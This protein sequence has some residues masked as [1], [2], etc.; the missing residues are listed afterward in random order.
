MSNGLFQTTITAFS[1]DASCQAL[2]AEFILKA[3]MPAPEEYTGQN[4][5]MTGVPRTK[6]SR[7]SPASMRFCRKD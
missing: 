7:F 4:Q 6:Y 2:R 5:F 1:V 3:R